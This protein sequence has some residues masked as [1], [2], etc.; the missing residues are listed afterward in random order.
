MHWLLSN[1]FISV[2]ALITIL[3]I[4]GFGYYG[5]NGGDRKDLAKQEFDGAMAEVQQFERTQP[6]PVEVNRAAKQKAIDDFRKQVEA[7]KLAFDPYRPGDLP[8]T[9]PESFVEHLKKLTKETKSEA[10]LNNMKLPEQFYCGFKQYVAGSLPA[11][12][13]TGLLSYQLDAIQEILMI[14]AGSGATELINLHRPVLAEE[15]NHVYQPDPDD[16]ARALPLEF[17]FRG[18]ERSVRKFASSLSANKNRYW[19][20][21]SV[22]VGNLKKDPPKTSDAKFADTKASTSPDAGLPFSDIFN[23]LEEASE[24]TS[25]EKAGEGTAPPAAS[26]VSDGGA[27]ILA[28]VLGNEELM[29]HIRADLMMFL[30]SKKLP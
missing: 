18:P 17:T 16:V 9:S 15:S 8:A 26:P 4:A 2:L 5:M 13:A 20:I 1:R 3:C 10:E 28:L 6:Y 29:V 14:L 27:K 19:V 11:R 12:S 25:E 7:L 22:R 23:Q 24:N 21:R 30:E